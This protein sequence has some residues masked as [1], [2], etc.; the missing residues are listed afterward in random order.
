MVTNSERKL[1]ATN[2][3]DIVMEWYEYKGQPYHFKVPMNE[4]KEKCKFNS[5]SK[6]IRNESV[7]D[8]YYN[9]DYSGEVIISTITSEMEIPMADLLEFFQH[10]ISEQIST[11]QKTNN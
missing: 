8:F 4:E 5:S 2:G 10:Y 1:L 3:K 9:A 7:Y 11:L 6:T